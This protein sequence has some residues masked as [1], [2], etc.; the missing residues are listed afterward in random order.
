MTNI[1]LSQKIV[2]LAA[3]KP[4]LSSDMYS[5]A[6]TFL[7]AQSKGVINPQWMFSDNQDWRNNYQTRLL[8]AGAN[9]M[10]IVSDNK[11]VGRGVYD[12]Y[13]FFVYRFCSVYYY[14]ETEEYF[15][16]Y[17]RPIYSQMLLPVIRLEIID[18]DDWKEYAR[19]KLYK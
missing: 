9:A 10:V 7:L 18:E 2:Y 8:E 3:P 14:D 4:Q 1:D 19:I 12:E 11:I 6:F 5:R 16:N 15:E 13:S 17:E